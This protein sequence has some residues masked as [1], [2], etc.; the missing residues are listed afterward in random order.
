MYVHYKT[1]TSWHGEQIGKETVEQYVERYVLNDTWG[2]DGQIEALK[3]NLKATQ[4][5][6][7]RLVS[8]LLDDGILSKAAVKELLGYHGDGVIISEE[9]HIEEWPEPD[10]D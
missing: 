8:K 7:S 4:D 2:H 1:K 5:F 10:G 3:S 6:V 9:E